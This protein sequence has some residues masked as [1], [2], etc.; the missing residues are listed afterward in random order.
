MAEPFLWLEPVADVA[1]AQREMQEYRLEC[2][3]LG[4]KSLVWYH[5]DRIDVFLFDPATGKHTDTVVWTWPQENN[6]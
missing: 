1:Q 5:A 4:V 6:Q 3:K 2:R